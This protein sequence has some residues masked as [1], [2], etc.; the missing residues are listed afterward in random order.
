MITAFVWL[1]IYNT[2]Q[3]FIAVDKDSMLQSQLQWN[4]PKWL[5]WRYGTGPDLMRVLVG[6]T[7]SRFQV[8]VEELDDPA[9]LPFTEL[10]RL[11]GGG[12]VWSGVQNSQDWGVEGYYVSRWALL[13]LVEL[14]IS[15]WRG[16]SYVVCFSMAPRSSHNYTSSRVCHSTTLLSAS[17]SSP[18]RRSRR[19]PA[20]LITIALISWQKQTY[21]FIIVKVF[22]Y[23]SLKSHHLSLYWSL[24][25]LGR[26][27][28]YL[29]CHYLCCKLFLQWQ[30]QQGMRI[31]LAMLRISSSRNQTPD[32]LILS[33]NP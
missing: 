28:E 33:L 27:S 2:L 12:V 18:S 11:C 24:L 8:V 5:P 16:G 30:R 4:T 6:V 25:N 32:L 23:Q 13:E 10:P 26:T 31:F 14:V 19:S 9:H 7:D 17:W 29:S 3:H 21:S 1:S 20:N 22:L 15:P